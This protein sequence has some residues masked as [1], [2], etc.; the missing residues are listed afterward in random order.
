MWATLGRLM[1]SPLRQNENAAQTLVRVTGNL[2]RWIVGLPFILGLIAFAG[3]SFNQ[4][5]QDRPYR[6]TGLEGIE[7]GMTPTEVTLIKGAPQLNTLIGKDLPNGAQSVQTPETTP[8]DSYTNQ[9]S[10]AA[11]AEP[12]ASGSYAEYRAERE[13][14]RQQANAAETN[15]FA[16]YRDPQGV[17][18]ER[19]RRR[20]A[21]TSTAE[22][23]TDFDGQG[24]SG[25]YEIEV[26]RFDEL[27]VFFIRRPGTSFRVLRVCAWAPR[28]WDSVIGVSGADTEEQVIRHL[29]QP[30]AVRVDDAGLS[31]WS[32]FDR[33]NLD[34]QFEKALVKSVCVGI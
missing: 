27:T 31:K 9:S 5:W 19:A 11:Q 15:R 13:A 10:A 32:S 7:I 24:F 18:A 14:R 17:E 20:F 22:P 1:W 3:F 30:D 26:M 29:G 2:L 16:R 6:L 33:Y 28:P 12:S 21:T 23:Q 34:V 25:D 4:W 8:R